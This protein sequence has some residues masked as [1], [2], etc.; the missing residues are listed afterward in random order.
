MKDEMAHLEHE[1]APF[2]IERAKVRLEMT[3]IFQSEPMTGLK[4]LRQGRRRPI[5]RGI[6]NSVGA[7]EGSNNV[8]STHN[9]V[10]KGG[11]FGPFRS[12][13]PTLP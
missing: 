5:E 3:N 11:H 4:R 10:C 7:L 2:K 9:L 6:P 8:L 13:N 12:Q 1:I